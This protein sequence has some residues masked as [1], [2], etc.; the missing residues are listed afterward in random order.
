MDFYSIFS[1]DET[2]LDVESML[3]LHYTFVDIFENDKLNILSEYLP[4]ENDDGFIEYKRT[5]KTYESK[6][7]KL[8]TQICWRMSEGYT[9]N[10]QYMCYY[11][12]GIENDGTVLIPLNDIDIINTI[13]FI[14]HNFANT[15][16]MYK[17]K[18]IKYNDNDLLIIKFW[19]Q[20]ILKKSDLNVILIGPSES[21]K[22]KFFIDLYN[23]KFDVMNNKIK[24]L[25]IFDIHNDE[26]KIKKTLVLHHQYFSVK[27]DSDIEYI[28]DSD[29]DSI[30]FHI[31]DTPGNSIISNIKFALNYNVDVILYFN[32]VNNIYDNILFNINN[33][34][35]NVLKISDTSYL[36]DFNIKILLRQIIETKYSHKHVRMLNKIYDVVLINESRIINDHR[37]SKFNKYIYYCYNLSNIH[38]FDKFSDVNIRNIQHKHKYKSDILVSNSISIEVDDFISK[39]IIGDVIEIDTLELSNSDT[40][41]HESL[42]TWHIIILNQIYFITSKIMPNKIIFDKTILLPA[43]FE[44]IPIFIIWNKNN[45][46]FINISF[47]TL[48]DLKC[49]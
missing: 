19:R 31:I 14:N 3:K 48:E 21:L 17:F 29:Y 28:N 43:K 13:S 49:V 11:I 24:N 42:I 12:I 26:T 1:I 34:F 9:Y 47:Y 30:D 41:I 18:T 36:S 23:D 20:Q 2:V 7:D 38:L 40:T 32:Q 10:H 33:I 45:E 35:N 37:F 5:L 46:Y 25:S 44:K 27:Y 22:T 39:T 16:I 15:D 4:I 6:I 8:K